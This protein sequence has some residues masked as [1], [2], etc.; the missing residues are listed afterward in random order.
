MAYRLGWALYWT[1]LALSGVWGL[2]AWIKRHVAVGRK[3]QLATFQP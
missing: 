3:V 1:C 2:N